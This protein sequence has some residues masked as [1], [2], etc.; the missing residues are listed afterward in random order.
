MKTA[1]SSATTTSS[2]W[3]SMYSHERVDSSTATAAMA[4]VTDSASGE[5]MRQRGGASMVNISRL[6]RELA[7]ST[8]S[9]TRF[10]ARCSSMT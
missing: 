6:T 7:S 2:R 4:A 9:S 3:F 10:A 8:S 5:P 1:K